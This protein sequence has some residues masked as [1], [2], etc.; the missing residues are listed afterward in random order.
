MGNND[1]NGIY[2]YAETDLASTFSTLL[3]TGQDSVSVALA[4]IKTFTDSRLTTLET[5]TAWTAYT[6]NM[7]T[8]W[9]LGNGTLN[10]YYA[11]AS[12]TVNYRIELVFGSTTVLAT[13]S[14]TVSVPFS[15]GRTALAET[16][17]LVVAFD[18]SASA[19]FQGQHMFGPGVGT[20]PS[21]IFGDGTS[22][23]TSVSG[24]RPFTWAVGD[25]ITI[26][27]SYERA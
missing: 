21:I 22:S 14:S 7:G 15:R 19:R 10:G 26:T 17:G 18:T 5:V 27:G 3:N 20:G 24:T 6:P 2:R 11:L 13:T 8:G 23:A 12:K 16:I 1:S 25:T 4:A 9:T